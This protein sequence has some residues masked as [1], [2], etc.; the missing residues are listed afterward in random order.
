M[1]EGTRGTPRK[2]SDAMYWLARL[3]V[4]YFLSITAGREMMTVT[5]LVASM[6]PAHSGN[7]WQR[8]SMSLG[9]QSFHILQYAT[10]IYPLQ[11]ANPLIF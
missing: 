6:E 9:F 1:A 5:V 10:I 4:I 2:K 3:P 8:T 7:P 11:I